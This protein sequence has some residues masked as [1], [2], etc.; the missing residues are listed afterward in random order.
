MV[1]LSLEMSPANRK[2]N[3]SK[4]AALLL[5]SPFLKAAVCIKKKK[6]FWTLEVLKNCIVTKGIS[7]FSDD[8]V[9]YIRLI[10]LQTTMINARQNIF[11][12]HYFKVLE[13]NQKQQKLEGI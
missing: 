8:R 4:P 3:E 5:S 9:A 7:G 2:R 10:L 6:S 11:K 12:I 1:F 13:S